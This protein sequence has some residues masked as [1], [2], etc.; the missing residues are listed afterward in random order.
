[1]RRAIYQLYLRGASSCGKGKVQLEAKSSSAKSNWSS[2]VATRCKRRL[3]SAEHQ[4]QLEV[5]NSRERDGGY[6][7]SRPTCA[8]CASSDLVTWRSTVARSRSS[9]WVTASLQPCI[10]RRSRRGVSARGAQAIPAITL[11]RTPGAPG[12]GELVHGND[13]PIAG[14]ACRLNDTVAVAAL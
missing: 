1:M 4:V 6:P 7:S 13:H 12:A 5:K 9:R 10:L 14:V 3:I 2:K 8:T 11:A